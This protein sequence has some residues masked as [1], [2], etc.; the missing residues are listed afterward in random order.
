MKQNKKKTGLATKIIALALLASIVLA[1]VVV[2]VVYF[3][4]A[5]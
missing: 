2:V 5:I 1:A 4:A 3:Q